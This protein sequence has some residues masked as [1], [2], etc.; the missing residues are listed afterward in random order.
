[1]LKRLFF[2]GFSASLIA[3]STPTLATDGYF[4]HG[5]GT[6]ARSMG[7]T[8]IG[9]SQDGFGGANNPAASLW[10]GNRTEV[11]VDLFKPS[12]SATFSP[13][14]GFD[15]TTDSEN[16]SFL[17]PELGLVRKVSDDYAWG[18]TVYGN[19][20]MNT[21]YAPIPNLLGPG[22]NNILGGSTHLGV[23]MSQLIIAPH[24][25]KALGENQSVGLAVLLVGQQ[26]K[27]YG[28]QAFSPLSSDPTRLTDLGYD[29]S[30]GVG[31]RLGY[32]IRL[33]EELTLG[34]NYSPQVQMS[35]FDQY[36]GLFAGQGGFDLP[37]NY[38]V[39]LGWQASENLTLAADYV[40]INYSAVDSVGLP[41]STPAPLGS[42]RAPGFGW[43]DVNVYKLGAQWVVDSRWTVRAG[44]NQSDNPVTSGDV[45]FNI[46]APGV[47]TKH[48]TL[49][50]G[51]RFDSGAQLNFSYM[52]APENS[53]TGPRP[54]AFGGGIDYVEMH[55]NALGIQ[56]SFSF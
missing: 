29:Q 18:V 55:Q 32:Q 50:L 31:L 11:G 22:M 27:V 41:S 20:G 54:A 47:I 23:D 51:Y 19:G 12:R 21:E 25:A 2:L 52:Y 48:Y 46:L 56:Y 37:E 15:I 13:A 34:A 45:T 3:L 10:S 28:I 36:A 16:E 6:V 40:R 38:G 39:G 49:G 17:I 7:G 8:S 24:A 35:E 26:F 14:P 53:V 33:S 42:N 9:L 5:Y 44:F 30:Y 43:N 4:T 1:M